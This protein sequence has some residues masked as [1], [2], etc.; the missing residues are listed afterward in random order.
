M[1]PVADASRID[2]ELAELAEALRHTRDDLWRDIFR[3][4]ADNLLDRRNDLTR[5]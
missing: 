1:T 4:R 2:R 5:S 3:K